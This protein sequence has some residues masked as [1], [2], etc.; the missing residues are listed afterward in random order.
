MT[1]RMRLADWIS[2]GELSRMQYEKREAWETS[3]MFNKRNYHMTA[4]LRLILADPER[5]EEIARE[6]LGE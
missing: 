2:G 4:F 1:W 6:A 3:V 5:A